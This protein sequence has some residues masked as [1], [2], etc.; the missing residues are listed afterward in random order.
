M[1]NITINNINNNPN[2]NLRELELKNYQ[3]W[4]AF[5]AEEAAKLQ[6]FLT[7]FGFDKNGFPS[8]GH[9]LRQI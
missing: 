8:I 7:Q 4:S 9:M 5:Y 1:S 3:N 6:T 2:E